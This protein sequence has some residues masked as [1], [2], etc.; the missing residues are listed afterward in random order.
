M[1]GKSQVHEPLAVEAAGGVFEQGDASLVG[2]DQVVVQGNNL[3]N[4]D[5]RVKWWTCT[6]INFKSLPRI[7]FTA[8][9]PT[10]ARI[11]DRPIGERK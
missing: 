2:G 3:A 8:A 11:L 9:P 5:L 1:A 6:L 4:R 7:P 10:I